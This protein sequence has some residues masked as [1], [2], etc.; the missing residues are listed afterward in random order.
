MNTI[1]IIKAEIERLYKTYRKKSKTENESQYYLGMADGLD[2]FE[3]YLDT[4]QE[5]PVCED[6]GDEVEK[7]RQQFPEVGFAKVS[8]IAHHFAQW[9]K[10]K[11]AK[12]WEED[13]TTFVPLSVHEE[14]KQRSYKEG[15][16]SMKEQM[17]KEAVE[18]RVVDAGI[19]ATYNTPVEY[20][21]PGDKVKVIIVKE[22]KQ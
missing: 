16:K 5:Q 15:K 2:L 7:V 1:E 13:G 4:L 22:D 17:M 14:A 3:Q 20:T 19:F 6:I 21:H 18:G 11:D 8:R 9:Q 10:E 12:R